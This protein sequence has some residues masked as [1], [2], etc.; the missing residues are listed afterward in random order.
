MARKSGFIRDLLDGESADVALS[1]YERSFAPAAEHS[2]DER[3]KLLHAAFGILSGFGHLDAANRVGKKYLE[4]WPNCPVFDYLMKAIAGEAS[5]DRSPPEYIVEFYNSFADGFDAKLAGVLGYDVPEKLCSL[6]RGATPANHKYDA[7]DAGCG[8]GF[9]GPLLRP[10]A[11][12]LIGVDLSPKMLEHAAKRDVYDR[13]ICEELTAFLRSGQ[14]SFDLVVAADVII[15]MGDLTELFDAA[16]TAIGDRGLFA[17]ST[18]LY[19]GEKYRIEPTGRF[20]HSPEYVR[21]QAAAAFVEEACVETAIRL[22]AGTQVPGNL[23]LFRRR[24]RG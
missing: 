6:V 10:M 23:F 20:A 4:L 21:T 17:F 13:L 19:A 12:Q 15:Y 22:E 9:C 14:G 2:D 7:I 24:P 5:L 8:T 18:E 16:A 1:N 11:R 3:R